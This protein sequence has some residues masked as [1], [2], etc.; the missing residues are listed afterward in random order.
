MPAR[1]VCSGRDR[2]E[3]LGASVQRPEEVYTGRVAF[4]SRSGNTAP[5]VGRAASEC[6]KQ[7]ELPRG[8]LRDARKVFRSLAIT[9]WTQ[10]G[11]FSG[12]N[13]RIRR[14]RSTAW[15]DCIT[16]RANNAEAELLFTR[17]LEARSRVLGEDHPDTMTSMN[18][19]AILYHAQRKGTQGYTGRATL[20]QGPRSSA[21]SV[22][23]SESSHHQRYGIACLPNYCWMSGDTPRPN[24]YCAMSWKLK[25]RGSPMAGSCTIHKLCCVQSSRVKKDLPRRNLCY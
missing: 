20:H 21:P 3:H 19:L 25:G 10:G 22:R 15:L 23:L 5:G 4:R 9:S 2:D 7:R 12:R 17:V 24:H 6:V 16:P 8:A 13:I 18:D 1:K 11:G 14:P